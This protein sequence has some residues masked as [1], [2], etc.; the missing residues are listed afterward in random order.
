ME[1]SLW[2]YVRDKLLPPQI[3]ATRI[4]SRVSPGFPDVHY[5]IRLE[6][7]KAAHT[8]TLEL[9]FLRKKRLPFGED[10]LNRDQRIWIDKEIDAGG[11]V[12]ILAQVHDR[13]FLM[14]GR[15][16]YRFNSFHLDD[17]QSLALWEGQMR[18]IDA[19]KIEEFRILL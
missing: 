8:G 17:F 4:E 11:T 16:A 15:E 14:H 18:K 7:F 19:E 6:L 13:L 5:T 12:R 2:R 9:K 1:D 3:H 10:G